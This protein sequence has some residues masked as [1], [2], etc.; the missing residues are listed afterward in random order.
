MW[1]RSTAFSNKYSDEK[2]GCVILLDASITCAI[3][4]MLA[5]TADTISH[6]NLRVNTSW[7]P[8]VPQQDGTI[9][10]PGKTTATKQVLLSDWKRNQGIDSAQLRGKIPNTWQSHWYTGIDSLCRQKMNNKQL[11]TAILQQWASS[12]DQGETENLLFQQQRAL[13]CQDW[14]SNKLLWLTD[15][16]RGCSRKSDRER[17]ES[18]SE[19]DNKATGRKINPER[20]ENFE[21]IKHMFKSKARLILVHVLAQVVRQWYKRNIWFKEK[22]NTFPHLPGYCDYWACFLI[23]VYMYIWG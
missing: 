14:S 16:S 21:C 17:Q 6:L 15:K 9:I 3:G 18:T 7:L 2:P 11:V 22:L 10:L 1:S 19:M 20:W 12:W 13:V 8:Q 5:H 4:R 23:D